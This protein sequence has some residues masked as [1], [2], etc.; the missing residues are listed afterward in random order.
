MESQSYDF[1]PDPALKCDQKWQNL[2]KPIKRF[3]ADSDKTES[4]ASVN[5][6]TPFTRKSWKY[7]VFF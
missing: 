7:W 4:A 5:D 3:A 6:N 2:L 1:G